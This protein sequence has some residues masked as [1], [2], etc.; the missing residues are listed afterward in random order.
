MF[1]FTRDRSLS[2]V[3]C[4]MALHRCTW[5]HRKTT[6][7]WLSICWQTVLIRLF[8]QRWANFKFSRCAVDWGQHSVFC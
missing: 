4:R 5:P 1:Y 7:R 8:Q 6:Q 3:C 2:M